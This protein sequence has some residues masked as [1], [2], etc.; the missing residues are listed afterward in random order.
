MAQKTAVPNYKKLLDDA[1][2]L[3]Y[4][5]SDTPRIDAEFL[6]QHV[7]AKPMAWLISH[8]DSLATA[9]H[10]K[11]YYSAVSDRQVGKPIAYITGSREFWTLNLTVN[12]SV[13]I[14]RP[15]TETLVEHALQRIPTNSRQLLDLG[16]GSGAIALALAKERPTCDV[17]A[18]DSQAAALKVAQANAALNG[19]SNI[20]F[21]Q[22]NWFDRI[23]KTSKFDLIAS[24]PP[25]VEIDDPHL[26]TGDLRFEPDSALIAA[27][28]GLS[29]LRII[30]NSAPQYLNEQGWLIV[31][32]GY[33]QE[34]EVTKIFEQVGYSEISC[35]RDINNLPRCTAG[36]YLR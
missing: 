36:Q 30:I 3:L 18:V 16:T 14:P 11:N 33:N 13:L 26:Q 9:E 7:I 22:S 20:S 35:F 15:D 17:I 34:T 10:I 24:N 31:E 23:T 1:T 8:G 21:L 6:L 19:I 25:Y 2:K 32:H 27:D 28:N 12:E 4:E 29:D 5:A